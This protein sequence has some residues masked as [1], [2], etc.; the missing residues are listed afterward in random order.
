MAISDDRAPAGE[1]FDHADP[2]IL[3][4]RLYE[5]ICR[6]V[7][8][9]QRKIVHPTQKFHVGR[10]ECLQAI[11]V[12]AGPGNLQ[13]QSEPPEC[14]DGELDPFVWHECCDHQVERFSRAVV[15]R[16]E[17]IDVH[18]R[19]NHLGLPVVVSGNSIGYRAGICN[20]LM[21]PIDC[22]DVPFTKPFYNRLD[23][24]TL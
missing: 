9:L 10:S 15:W 13:R 24:H 3:F 17:K 11:V 8:F 20:E 4:A 2:E 6:T 12:R 21:H 18:G 7:E 22:W 5:G 1:C 19:I 14:L 23:C 16:I